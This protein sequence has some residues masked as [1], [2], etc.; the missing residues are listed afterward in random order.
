MARSVDWYLDTIKEKH[1]LD[2]DREIGRRLGFVGTPVTLWRTKRSFPAPTTMVKLAELADVDPKEALG[3][4][5]SWSLP[6]PARKHA[7]EMADAWRRVKNTAAAILVAIA[8]SI[9]FATP[10]FASEP[11]ANKV[12]GL[13]T[14]LYI[15]ANRWRR[16]WRQRLGRFLSRNQSVMP[17]QPRASMVAV[18]TT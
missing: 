2:S 17:A 9:G 6:E 14:S 1:G 12:T 10:S 18:S 4:L 16:S 8:L 15:M 7:V 3:D 5:W 11:R 13:I